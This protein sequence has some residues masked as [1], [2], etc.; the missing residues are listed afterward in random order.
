MV[1]LLAMIILLII[2]TSLIVYLFKGKDVENCWKK[3]IK[4]ALENSDPEV[5]NHFIAKNDREIVNLMLTK[6][7]YS[8]NELKQI[9]LLNIESAAINHVIENEERELNIIQSFS[10]MKQEI[11]DIAN[12]RLEERRGYLKQLKKEYSLIKNNSSYSDIN[13]KKNKNNEI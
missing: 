12:K 7:W 11:L 10:F 13:T 5:R 9:Y 8:V 1:L 4:F 2:L 3:G 6:K